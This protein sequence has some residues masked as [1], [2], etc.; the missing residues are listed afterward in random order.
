MAQSTDYEMA[1]MAACSSFE[2]EHYDS[3]SIDEI[4]EGW[5]NWIENSKWRLQNPTKQIVEESLKEF[6]E[7]GLVKSPRSQTISLGEKVTLSS[8]IKTPELV[9]PREEEAKL[10]R[11]EFREMCRIGINFLPISGG[12]EEDFVWK[13]NSLDEK[14]L[15]PFL[16]KT[17][18]TL[19]FFDLKFEC[20]NIRSLINF[21]EDIVKTRQITPIVMSYLLYSNFHMSVYDGLLLANFVSKGKMPTISMFNE[22]QNDFIEVHSSPE[23]WLVLFKCVMIIIISQGNLDSERYPQFVTS[24]LCRKMFKKELTTKELKALLTINAKTPALPIIW[25]WASMC[26]DVWKRSSTITGGHGFQALFKQNSRQRRSTDEEVLFKAAEYLCSKKFTIFVP[27]I[28]EFSPPTSLVSQRNV[29]LAAITAI[30]CGVDRKNCFCSKMDDVDKE[31]KELS[32]SMASKRVKWNVAKIMPTITDK[33]IGDYIALANWLEADE[34]SKDQSRYLLLSEFKD[35]VM[36]D[37]E[38]SSAKLKRT[39]GLIEF[40]T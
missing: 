18:N 30:A 25:S 26:P 16:K 19:S 40:G 9:S 20:N 22:E 3:F 29:K 13:W 38:M 11:P 14:L 5:M 1:W 4:R 21:V 31:M 35:A 39:L 32:Y 28:C 34:S 10:V 27:S 33:E 36:R 15:E 2:S 8:G 12:E 17:D 24:N 6:I 23:T 7:N 37:R